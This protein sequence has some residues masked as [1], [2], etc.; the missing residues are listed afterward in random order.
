MTICPHSRHRCLVALL[1]LLAGA[2]AALSLHAQVVLNE[3]VAA[4]SDRLLRRP[5]PG[6]PQLGVTTPW[7]Q[8]AFD[9]SAWRSANGAFGFGGFAAVAVGTDTSLA[10]QNKTPSLYL[11]RAFMVT[12]DQ[13]AATNN[14]ELVMLFNDGFIAF[15]NG[16]EV[17]RRNMGNP[18]MFAYHD[19]LAFN[20]ATN[21]LATNLN[22]GPALSR[23]VPGT[24]WLC[25]QAH[26]SALAGAGAETFLVKADLRL[27]TPTPVVFVVANGTWKTFVGTVE[28][29]GGLP[30]VGLLAGLDGRVAWA[31]PNFNDSGWPVS[32]GPAGMDGAVPPEYQLG[33]NLVSQMLNLAG[34]L[35]TRT[36][37]TVSTGEAA[38]TQPLRLVLDYDD[39]AIVYVNGWEVARRNVGTAGALTPHEALATSTH[40]ANGDLGGTVSGAEVTLQLAAAN[41]LLVP[42]QN[43]LAVQ[44]HNSS[45]ASA[46]LVARA[47]L[48][49]TGTGARTLATPA[50][51]VRYF[52]GLTEPVQGP[53]EG[54]DTGVEEDPPDTEG[55]WVELHNLAA[56]NVSLAGWAL[57]DDPREP[58]KWL[59]PTDTVIPGNGYLIVQATGK[60][61]GPSSGATYLHTN[62]KLASSG[63]YLALVDPSGAV[64]SQFAPVYPPQSPFFSY[65]R[66]PVG[67]LA[68][69]EN[70]TPGAPNG[71]RAYEDWLSPPTCTPEGGFFTSPLTV[72]LSSPTP[73]VRLRY[74]RDGSEPTETNGYSYA[75]PIAVS[76]PTVVRARCFRDGSVPSPIVTHTYLV[77]QSLARRSLAAI[78]LAGDP[79]LTF[80]G[81]NTYYGPTNGEGIFAIKGGTYLGEPWTNAGNTLAF[82][83]PMQ[84]GRPFEK[85]ASLEVYASNAPSLRR[86]IGVRISGSDWSKPRYRLTDHAMTRFTPTDP[87]QKP[88]F[89]LFFRGDLG[90]RP[91][92]FPL[93]PGSPVTRFY[94]VRLRAGKNDISNPFIRDELVRRIFLETGQVGSHGTFTTLYINGVFKGYFNLCEHLREGF[95][96]EHYGSSAAWDVR[97]VNQIASGDTIHW[98]GMFSFL[99]TNNLADTATYQRVHGWLDVD[100][101]IDY[102]LVNVLGGTWDW[103]NNNWVASRERTERGRWRF[104]VWDAEGAFGIYGRLPVHDLFIG[105]TNGD[106]VAES[107]EW[108]LKLDIG[109]DAQTTT[110]QYLPAL[111]TLLKVAPEF[112]LRWADRA[113]KHFFHQGALS[114]A[115]IEPLFVSLRNQINPIMAETI[116][117][118][119]DTS[120]YVNWVQSGARTNAVFAQMRK[121]GLWPATLAPQFGP[122]GGALAPGS[123]VYITNLNSGGTIYYTTNGLDPRAP[124]GSI[125]GRAYTGP[126]QLAFTTELKARVRSAA[127]DWS[128]L[129]EATF[130]LQAMP[131]ILVTEIMYHPLNNQSDLEFVELKNA[132]TVPAALGGARFSQ[133]LDY[134]IADGTVLG[135]GQF[136]VIARSPAAFA[137][138]YPGVACASNGYAPANLANS[139]ER[140]TLVDV[141]SNVLFSVSYGDGAPWPTT[142]DGLGFS[143]V[144]RLPNANP[145]P[146][147][148]GSWRAST[149]AGGSPGADDPEPILPGVLVNEVLARSTSGEPD[150]IELYNP[151]AADADISGW[152]L[153][154][155]KSVPDKYHLPAG[156]R[157][158]AGGYARFTEAHFNSVPGAP[159]CFALNALGDGAYLYA[160]DAVG[161]LLGY[162]HGFEFGSAAEDVTFGRVVNSCGVEKFPAQVAATPLATNA[163]PRVG[164]V[165]ITEVL[166]APASGRQEF[167]EVQ[168]LSHQSVALFDPLF[169]TNT[170]RIEGFDFQFPTNV[171]LAPGQFAVICGGTP[172]T[173]RS[174][175]QLPATTLVFGPAAGFL[176]DAGERVALQRPDA[177][178]TD[179]FTGLPVVPYIDVDVVEYG[180]G[181]GWPTAIG[182][183]SLERIRD[184]DFGDDPGNW[185]LVTTN[186]SP[187]RPTAWDFAAW[188]QRSF[189]PADLANPDIVG[190]GAD[191]DGDGLANLLEFAFGTNPRVPN[192]A[193]WE[194]A[195]LETGGQSYLS[196]ECRRSLA[197]SPVTVMLEVGSDLLTWS[198]SVGQVVEVLRR[199]DGDGYESLVL[200]DVEPVSQSRARF[201]RLRVTLP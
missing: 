91:Q 169:P 99:R 149:V 107:G 117:Q 198:S 26:N 44:I 67:G 94:D 84:S 151:T 162:S 83:V 180:N 154:D 195:L 35:Y 18:G 68:Y 140:I 189:A 46:D 87:Y 71:G 166:Y 41:K 8:P 96:Q 1:L 25:I 129:Q 33:T 32:P 50:D 39:G 188:C 185:R 53:E 201:A 121:Y 100:N 187:A 134:T 135:P 51:P 52:V 62:F 54:E 97:Q 178:V 115:R 42:G 199:D 56:T 113:E 95:M 159:E 78:C 64:A 2:G 130:A 148:A 175:Y 85:P 128:P 13:A 116:G 69:F 123:F 179:A 145:A 170:W 119:V 184:A 12:A 24:N 20:P 72:Q 155:S 48:S 181:A 81:P 126:L 92:E 88:S 47:T 98:N 173:F 165:V 59:F 45:L 192:S 103:P 36:A 168:N 172:A 114:R 109:T 10:M 167:V 105:D 111:Y 127:G 120:F 9:D 15:L 153:S 118:S 6:Y 136:L 38:S 80:Y 23:L 30:D 63:D 27:A 133:G 156:T 90:D 55:D 16:V 110:W 75:G 138:R 60:D 157:I 65:G 152:F 70:A 141:A 143:L 131:F 14:V 49:T 57:T 112:R 125:V 101:L 146:D 86:D 74:T 150:W 82:N 197:A 132:G 174:T 177:P 31:A 183:A 163:G 108:N 11:R 122:H 142:P 160:A 28:P 17:A 66:N 89:N 29:S 58:T 43:I 37:F 147:A 19:Q 176:D 137:A 102:L 196:V 124:G 161:N 22:L 193:P 3:I 182:G 61:I 139:G 158:P 186:G 190:P 200:R 104:H 4:N 171:T 21:T 7:Y 79:A 164:P 191:P 5:A 106:G 73:D 144:T 34:S 40:N 194:F 76:G 77:G 93:F